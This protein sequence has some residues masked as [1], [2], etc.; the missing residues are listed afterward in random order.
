MRK[1]GIFAFF[2][3]LL[4]LFQLSCN[5][6]GQVIPIDK[7]MKAF[8]SA[9]G[10][11]AFS[12]G[13]RGGEVIYVTNLNDSGEGSLRNAL[14]SKDPR[15]VVFAVSGIIELNSLIVIENPFLTIAGQTAPENGITLRNSG[16]YIKTHDVVIRHIRIR[17]GDSSNGHKFED[18]DALTVGQE[19]Y[20]VIIDHVSASWS[21]DE[22]F[23]TYYEPQFISFQWCI[24]SEALSHSEH[25]E[26]EHSKGLLVGDNTLKVSIHHN[27]FAHINDRAP[28][29]VKGGSICDVVNNINYNWGEYAFSFAMNNS[30]SGVKINL[31]GNHFQKGISSTGDFFSEPDTFSDSKLCIKD[32]TGDDP[33]LID[34]NK[35]RQSYISKKQYLVDAPVDWEDNIE[36]HDM[37]IIR[38]SLLHNAG[39]IL[40]KRD[41]VD[42]RIMNE[43]INTTGKIIDSQNEVGGYPVW[44]TVILTT[45][46][47]NDFDSDRDGMPND[48]ELAYGL[49]PNNYNDGKL[50]KDGNGYSNLEEYLN[51]K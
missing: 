18:R 43:I 3:M 38:D 20:N 26:G 48:W 33:L 14:Q 13:G 35:N 49:D 27:V 1:K 44:Q 39:A 19:S 4:I 51:R 45:Q 5:K 2:G 15:T 36:I 23:S 22:V 7:S 47:L 30:S 10:F 8:P 50:D 24:I 46:Q 41:A 9:E 29:Q 42:E 34:F 12:K 25:P 31:I 40:P 16:L 28:V 21:V 37:A 32:N 6:P 17:P 11:G